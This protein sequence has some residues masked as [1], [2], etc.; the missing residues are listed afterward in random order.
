[1]SIIFVFGSNLAGIH[2]AGAALTARKLPCGEDVMSFIWEPGVQC[3]CINDEWPPRGSDGSPLPN[4]YPIKGQVYDVVRV[5]RPRH[6]VY[7]TFLQI[8]THMWRSDHFRPVKK[9]NIDQFKR[10]VIDPQTR[11]VLEDV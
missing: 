3:V 4:P 10:L 8:K 2:G 9:T 11:K 7:L 5:L 6:Y 1:M